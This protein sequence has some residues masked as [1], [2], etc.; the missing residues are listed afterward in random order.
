VV[1]VGD[2]SARNSLLGEDPSTVRARR[3]GGTYLVSK[4]EK[5]KVYEK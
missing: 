1:R 4:E 5:E 2:P 3:E